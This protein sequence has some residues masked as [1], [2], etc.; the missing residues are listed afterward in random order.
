MTPE[1]LDRQLLEFLRE[2]IR[3]QGRDGRKRLETD[4]DVYQGWFAMR[5]AG[6]AK[7]KTEELFR[8]LA[9]LE[10]T[11]F[12]FFDA[13]AD[14]LRGIRRA[15]ERTLAELEPEV[16]AILRRHGYEVD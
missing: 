7:L 2:E 1:A 14:F 4:L 3:R 6:K 12:Q 15:P 16:A 13:F 8:I 11:P 10:L 5:L 9:W